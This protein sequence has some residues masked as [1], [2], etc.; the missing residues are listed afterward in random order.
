MDT[1]TPGTIDNRN[2]QLDE[3]R[4]L[5]NLCR[6]CAIESIVG[7][8][9]AARSAMESRVVRNSKLTRIRTSML[10]PSFAQFVSELCH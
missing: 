6:N 1:K 7:Q 4:Q 8:C 9:P 5:R 10:A 2:V 3:R